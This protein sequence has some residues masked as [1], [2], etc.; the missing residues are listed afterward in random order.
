M[1]EDS[2]RQ[3]GNPANMQSELNVTYYCGISMLKIKS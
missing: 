1:L 2:S 3:D